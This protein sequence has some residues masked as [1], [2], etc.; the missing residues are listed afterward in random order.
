MK[1]E[2]KL[3]HGQ[4]ILM[5]KGL[6]T[7]E[8]RLN[9]EKRKQIKEG[10]T[11]EFT[12][13]KTGEKLNTKVIKIH[14]YPSFEELY[15]HADKISIGYKKHERK[16]PKDMESIYP[17]EKQKEYGVLGIE[18]ET[19]ENEK[20]KRL[21]EE[22][23][24]IKV[25]KV[26]TIDGGRASLYKII[27]KEKDYVLKIYQEE[28][29]KDYIIRENR[30]LNHLKQKNINV[31]TFYQTK[32]NQ[33]Y[34]KIDNTI[35]VLKDFIEG[36]TP[37]DNTASK[38][39][40]LE[41]ATCLSKLVVALE[42]LEPIK[43]NDQ[44]NKLLNETLKQSIIKHQKLLNQTT[45][46]Q[47]IKD[48]NIK[49]DLVNKAIENKIFKDVKN[50][51]LKTTHGDFCHLQ[52]IYHNHQIKSVINFITTAKTQISLEIIRSCT[53]ADKNDKS[54]YIDIENLKA[55]TKKFMEKVPLKEEDL[56]YMPHIFL[57][58]LLNSTYGYE[59]YLNG[60]KEKLKYV[61]WRTNTA[62]YLYNNLDKISNELI[63]LK[64]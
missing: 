43:I 23:Y 15:K 24:N 12:S 52:I 31:A 38:E 26:Q 1:H 16:D 48:L 62:L 7:I 35:A 2:M 42:D 64:K 30:V 29:K 41:M 57:A 54:G 50:L 19:L 4:F 51:T 37:K 17:K 44:T 32:T 40:L 14:H 56:K 61:K 5:K 22:N 3:K 58:R 27:T 55:Y 10:D 47:I 36:Y 6:K 63:K 8:L 45:E 11:I 21:V 9:D 33:N 34:F 39:E 59:E 28:Y 18:L 49:I 20:I 60:N 53:M 46:K 25:K 13:T